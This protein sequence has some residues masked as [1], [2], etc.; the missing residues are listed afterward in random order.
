MSLEM[1]NNALDLLFMSPGE[2]KKLLF[3]GGD[4]LANFALLK[5]TIKLA[6]SKAKFSNKKIEFGMG[7]N[8]T[9]ISKEIL[10]C[11]KEHDVQVSISVDGVGGIHDKRRIFK[12]GRPTFKIIEENLKR[13]IDYLPEQNISCLFGIHYTDIKDIFTNFKF[14]VEKQKFKSIH[15]QPLQTNH[16]WTRN[17]VK[18]FISELIKILRYVTSSIKNDNFIFINKLSQLFKMEFKDPIWIFNNLT[19]FP[20][21]K[22]TLNPFD[23]YIN[24]EY[25]IGDL[26]NGIN[27]FPKKWTPREQTI[28][29]YDIISFR[30]NLIS[31]FARRILEK[32]RDNDNYKRYVY[33]AKKRVFE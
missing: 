10:E 9:Y 30:D 24:K 4:P 1:I 22:I 16:E 14:L 19:F 17:E 7:T 12:N 11:I 28:V 32:S 5:K 3:F 18:I 27:N 21:G 29:D 13:F 31:Q 20:D 8:G 33:E 6:K 15:I 2:K 23:Y 26:F 25:I